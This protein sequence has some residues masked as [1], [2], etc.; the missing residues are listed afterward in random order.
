M[1]WFAKISDDKWIKEINIIYK[2]YDTFSLP[3]FNDQVVMD[4]HTN[5]LEPIDANF[6]IKFKKFYKNKKK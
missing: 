4:A 5:K 3:G 1:W 6:I 2:N